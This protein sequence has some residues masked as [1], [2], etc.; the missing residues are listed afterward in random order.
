[1]K[2]HICPIVLLTALTL[3]LIAGCSK[4]NQEALILWTDNVEFASYAE[5]FNSAQKEIK[6]AAVYKS[7]LVN[8][9]ADKKSSAAPDLIAGS[10]LSCGIS[11]RL[12][13]PINK[14]FSEDLEET[15]FYPDL[16]EAGRNGKTQY[17]LPVSFNLG[18]FVFDS[19]NLEY[20][21]ESNTITIDQ[22]KECS[23]NFNVK[24]KNDIY[25]KMAFAPQWNPD[26]LYEV[27]RT[28]DVKFKI[29]NNDLKFNIPLYESTCKFLIDWTDS[30]NSSYNEEKDFAFKY[31]YTPFNK[32]VL[33]QKSLFAYT[34][35]RRLLSL[36]EDQ[37]DKIDFRWFVQNGK[38]PV[39][40]DMVMMGI[41]RKSKNKTAALK[42]IQWFMNQDSQE[43]MLKRRIEMNLDTNTFGIAGGFSSLIVVNEQVLPVYYKYLLAKTP[44]SSI[45]KSPASYPSEWNAIKKEIIIPGM[46]SEISG[47]RDSYAIA[48]NFKE[49]ANSKKE[50]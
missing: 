30:I 19:E 39:Q 35:S 7:D 50:D 40:E 2:K 27:L 48:N 21:N 44:S 10:W 1:M 23:K 42:F 32:Q 9:L 28:N 26:F 49:W 5:L 18:T 16:L 34:T 15:D 22:I 25:E 43:Q 17:L 45:P 8:N 3:T 38:S 46:L 20:V 14:I 47:K 24:N 13:S 11:K 33:Q 41:S 12:F 37:L 4:K 6:V 31:L 36:S 29:E